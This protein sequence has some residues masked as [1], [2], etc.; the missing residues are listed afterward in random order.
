MAIILDKKDGSRGC[1]FNNRFIFESVGASASSNMTGFQR[2][3]KFYS[4]LT[5]NGNSSFFT[6]VDC[7]LSGETYWGAGFS[8]SSGSFFYK[9]D[10]YGRIIIYSL[11]DSNVNF[12]S[13]SANPNS[14][15]SGPSETAYAF[16]KQ[17]N[18]SSCNN[19]INIKTIID[20]L[21]DHH[22]GPE[23]PPTDECID[24][25]SC[26]G[27]DG[28]T[29]NSDETQE[30]NYC[31][32]TI[33]C[34]DTNI[35]STSIRWSSV[36]EWE[37]FF[38]LAKQSSSIKLNLLDKNQSQN[39]AGDKC[40]GDAEGCWVTWYGTTVLDTGEGAGS[41]SATS[42]R[43][44]TRVRKVDLNDEELQ[45]YTITVE[46]KYYLQIPVEGS[47]PIRIL[48]DSGT[49]TFSANQS[50]GGKHEFTN[51]DF[52]AQ[53]GQPIYGCINITRIDRL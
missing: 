8:S 6:T 32:N 42:Q 35:C 31:Y 1:A 22:Y 24:P 3:G 48:V 13:F 37:K 4:K 14:G 49:D 10:E 15:F 9:V 38:N 26:D 28:C 51:E 23:Y 19:P 11:N 5:T 16:F 41:T 40:E 36:Q 29:F 7:S 30:S 12:N 33:P 47:S 44:K 27:I 17:V 20:C 53:V 25:I 21:W 18:D 52:Q 34:G 39:C 46:S 45:K 50:R 2:Y 43:W